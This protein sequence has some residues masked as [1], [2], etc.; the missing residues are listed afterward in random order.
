MY[1]Y[2]TRVSVLKEKTLALLQITNNKAKI[3]ELKNYSKIFNPKLCYDSKWEL[4]SEHDIYP[5]RCGKLISHQSL[6][7]LSEGV[8]SYE[9]LVLAG[10]TEGSVVPAK[11]FHSYFS[12]NYKS[13]SYKI[14]AYI[15]DSKLKDEDVFQ[16]AS[17]V[18]DKLIY[19]D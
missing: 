4:I 5:D 2:A 3:F 14:C 11:L 9:K 16:M 15:E 12:E 13:T 17:S 10:H 18:Y 8:L 7:K 1:S 19:E 6:A